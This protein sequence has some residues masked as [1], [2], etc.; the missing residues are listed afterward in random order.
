MTGFIRQDNRIY[1]IFL[2]TRLAKTLREPAKLLRSAAFLS[3]LLSCPNSPIPSIRL[4][5]PSCYPVQT[6]P[7]RPSGYP[8]PCSSCHP[9][10]KP[11][12][13]A[14]SHQGTRPERRLFLLLPV[15]Y[16]SCCEAL[17]A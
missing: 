6:P 12:P 9:G 5:C 2:R 8:V 1:W 15:P 3:I 13:P 10:R 4:S 7:S 11:P 16:L 14:E 17:S